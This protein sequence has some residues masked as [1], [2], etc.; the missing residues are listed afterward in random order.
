[1]L[2]AHIEETMAKK[3]PNADIVCYPI[4]PS[5][6]FPATYPM[7]DPNPETWNEVL[8]NESSLEKTR[9]Y[10]RAAVDPFVCYYGTGK[11]NGAYD[12]EEIKNKI[13]EQKKDEE[14][15]EIDE[16]NIDGHDIT[17]RPSLTLVKSMLSNEIEQLANNSLDALCLPL[18]SSDY[19]QDKVL[20][21]ILS[22]GI[23]TVIVDSEASAKLGIFFSIIINLMKL[24]SMLCI[25]V[26]NNLFILSYIMYYCIIFSQYPT[27]YLSGKL[28]LVSD[29]LLPSIDTDDVFGNFC[30]PQA[31]HYRNNI[32][33]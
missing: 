21:V 14:E 2:S 26:S 8:V 27:I 25:Y 15:F 10:T 16:L 4:A 5:S 30:I 7:L 12:P 6:A 23:D 33:S 28:R 13:K 22:V 3:M 11:S 20:R 19:I 9:K 31:E 1:M 17:T 18:K 29:D 24:L 32:T